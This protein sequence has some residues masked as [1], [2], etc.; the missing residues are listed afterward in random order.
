MALA[1]EIAAFGDGAHDM[2]ETGLSVD[3]GGFGAFPGTL[4]M[5]ENADRSGAADQ[6][7]IGG[8]NDLQ[9]TG[10]EI[11]ASPNNSAGTVYLAYQREDLAWSQSFAFTLVNPVVVLTVADMAQQQAFDG[12]VIVVPGT[13]V[14]LDIASEHAF[15]TVVLVIDGQVQPA[16]MP[17][18]QVLDA[19]LLSQTHLLQVEDVAQLQIFDPPVGSLASYL[20]VTA[21]KVVPALSATV[22]TK[23]N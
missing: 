3:G 16:P 8:G 4:W 12:A 5:F 18:L 10:V 11:P 22:S 19:G 13:V 6:L 20:T 21:I 17:Q 23:P 1:P 15:D 7:T 9:L 2:G 14:P